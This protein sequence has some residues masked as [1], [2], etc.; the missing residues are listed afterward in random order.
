MPDVTPLSKRSPTRVFN[1]TGWLRDLYVSAVR[2][3]T[4]AILA[5][6][7]TN[8][9]EAIAPLALQNISMSWQ[10]AAA[11]GISALVFDIVRYVN[12]HPLPAEETAVPF[13]PSP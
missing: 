13:P 1:W 11:A 12:L 6:S 9:A 10:Q 7:G 8:T 2:A 4:G 5:F 3:S